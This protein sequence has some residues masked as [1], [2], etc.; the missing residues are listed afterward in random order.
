MAETFTS[1]EADL[2][3]LPALNDLTGSL[4]DRV[5]FAVKTAILNLD[6]LPGAPIRKTAICDQLG[7][8]RS[9]VSDALAKLSSE[10]LVDIVPQSGTRVARLSMIAIGEDIFFREAL[11][12]A[13]AR[14]AATHRSDETLARLLRNLE[15]QRL[16]IADADRE[17]FF[18]TDIA[19]HELI[20]ETT[21]VQ[22]LPGTVRSL[23]FHVD[24]A[25][26][27]LVPEPGRLAETVEEHLDV[28]EA[29]RSQNASAAEEAMRHHIRQT[30]KRLAPLETTCP[31]LFD[32]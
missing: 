6:F 26:M 13:A 32:G 5:Y 25:R 1:S 9:P 2:S 31:D 16:L 21:G 3:K 24:R 27:L 20:L 22:R 15:M 10:G 19:M 4:A 11:E 18:R 17:D 23:S 12:G 8:S 7:V 29:I 28:I 14:H 30:I